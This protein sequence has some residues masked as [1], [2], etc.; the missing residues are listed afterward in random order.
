MPVSPT[1]EERLMRISNGSNSDSSDMD[2]S[3]KQQCPFSDDKQDLESP[4]A[5][6]H[7]VEADYIEMNRLLKLNCTQTCIGSESG[8]PFNQEPLTETTFY[9]TATVRDDKGYIDW[10]G[11]S[12]ATRVQM[13]TVV[14][15]RNGSLVQSLDSVGNRDYEDDAESKLVEGGDNV[16][17]IIDNPY[18]MTNYQAESNNTD[19]YSEK[20]PEENMGQTVE[21]EIVPHI[22]FRNRARYRYSLPELTKQ[23]TTKFNMT[24]G[25]FPIEMHRSSSLS[26]PRRKQCGILRKSRLLSE[27]GDIFQPLPEDHT[28][29][30]NEDMINSTC[31]SKKGR[32]SSSILWDMVDNSQRN[33]ENSSV[34][35]L[36]NDAEDSQL[37]QCTKRLQVPGQIND[38]MSSGIFSRDHSDSDSDSESSNY[39]TNHLSRGDKSSQYSAQNGTDQGTLFH[40]SPDTST[41]VTTARK[42]RLSNTGW[43]PT[44]SSNFQ[45][46]YPSKMRFGLTNDVLSTDKS[47]EDI[48]NAFSSSRTGDD[49]IDIGCLAEDLTESKAAVEGVS[50]KID[51]LNND[52]IL[53][54]KEIRSLTT[55][56]RL[57]V[58]QQNSLR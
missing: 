44:A 42:R 3:G 4:D 40:N 49:F 19:L 47:Q 32:D 29:L 37:E 28:V 18:F 58:E 24:P 1:L 41:P 13:N 57:L 31:I 50:L 56:V 8:L 26:N 38:R 12:N 52:V 43:N 35:S 10:V 20:S 6:G 17:T 15:D 9:D 7:E 25:K 30:N 48:Q 21:E 39:G 51:R 2:E 55:L 45:G 54:K 14:K 36:E 33:S 11:D 46:A 53:L 5:L 22:M 16:A 34:K 23:S 27:K